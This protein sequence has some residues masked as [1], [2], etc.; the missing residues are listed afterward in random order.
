MDLL[1]P[2]VV[3]ALTPPGCGPVYTYI[4]AVVYIVILVFQFIR[5]NA[6]ISVTSA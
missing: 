5:F 2:G 4:H 3:H 6:E 1:A